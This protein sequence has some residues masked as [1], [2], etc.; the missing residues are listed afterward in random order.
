MK[1]GIATDS[2]CDI[3]AWLV[4]QHEIEVV[5]AVLVMEGVEYVDGRD[6]TREEFYRRLPG[7]KTSPTTAS[8]S[9]RRVRQCL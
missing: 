3:P 6:I 2:T 8:P 9:H 7:L 1:I 5:P 4:E